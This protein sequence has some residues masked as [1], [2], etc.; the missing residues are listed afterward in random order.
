MDAANYLIDLANKII[1]ER[2]VSPEAKRYDFMDNMIQF[3]EDSTLVSIEEGEEV[4]EVKKTLSNSEIVAQAIL[5]LAAGYINP[6]LALEFISYNLAKHPAVQ[7]T[8][9][10]EIDRVLEKHVIV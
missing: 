4:K 6:H 7:E 9:I 8:L 2:K 1:A 5:F 3:G 10:K